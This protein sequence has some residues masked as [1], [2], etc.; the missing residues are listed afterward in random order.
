M[1][2][3]EWI[4]EPRLRNPVAAIAF[5]GWND[6]GDAATGVV[7]Y[8]ISQYTDGPIAQIDLENYMNFQ[9][10]RPLISIDRGVRDI[11]WPATGLFGIQLDDHDHDV[12]AVL[13]E[14][15]HLRW[16]SYCGRLISTLRDL[17]VERAV[18]FGAFIG[19]IP[20]TI[21]PQLFGLSTRT[22]FYEQLNV[23]QSSYEGPTGITGVLHSALVG[24][25][26]EASSIWAGVPHYLAANPDPKATRALLGKFNQLIDYE[27]D[28][29]ELDVEVAEYEERVAEAVA[30]SGDI[31]DYVRELEDSA[32]EISP[33]ES[34]QLVEEIE[35]FLREPD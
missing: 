10:S 35:R 28:T 22:D 23:H 24:E 25:G 2:E 9:M 14:E 33:A 26:F 17:G 6:A 8:L 18:T 34:E 32:E 19:Q 29:S 1:S 11:H 12:I 15:P 3:I 16:P 31:V 20:H 7:E 27:I 5:Q 13:S 4:R 21:P 30:E